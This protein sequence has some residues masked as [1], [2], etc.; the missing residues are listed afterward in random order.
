MGLFSLLP[1]VC[2]YLPNNMIAQPEQNILDI[3]QLLNPFIQP[4]SQK[5]HFRNRMAF[6]EK[7]AGKKK[8]RTKEKQAHIHSSTLG[9][10]ASQSQA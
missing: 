1:S 8:K 3:E 6:E 7:V 9:F 2:Q 5:I 4:T 10:Y